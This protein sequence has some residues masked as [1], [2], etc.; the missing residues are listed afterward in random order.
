MRSRVSWQIG[1]FTHAPRETRS[2]KDQ[3]QMASDAPI[4]PQDNVQKYREFFESEGRPEVAVETTPAAP[5]Q[6]VTATL[7]QRESAQPV[8]DG[9]ELKE[10]TIEALR[11]ML[12]SL[13]HDND[14]LRDQIKTRWDL[15]RTAMVAMGTFFGLLFAANLYGQYAATSGLKE[16]SDLLQKEIDNA[17]SQTKESHEA[18]AELKKETETAVGN[19]KRETENAVGEL[20]KET[21]ISA[22]NHA[23]R[24]G[25]LKTLI[26]HSERRVTRQMSDVA[27]SAR[28]INVVLRNLDLGQESFA[29]NNPQR[30]LFYAKQ[31]D[32]AIESLKTTLEPRSELLKSLEQ[33]KPSIG[34]LRTQSAWAIGNSTEAQRLADELIAADGTFVEARHFAGLSRLERAAEESSNELARRNHL[35]QAIGHLEIAATTEDKHSPDL[36]FLAAACYDAGYY[37]DCDKFATRYIQEFPATEIERQR[38]SHDIQA[39]LMVGSIWKTLAGLVQDPENAKNGVLMSCRGPMPEAMAVVDARVLEKLL[40]RAL[41]RSAIYKFSPVQRTRYEGTCRN[42]LIYI[43][44][45]AGCGGG[46]PGV[47]PPYFP[48]PPTAAG[49]SRPAN[50]AP[51]GPAAPSE[52]GAANEPARRPAKKDGDVRTPAQVAPPP[53]PEV[54]QAAEEAAPKPKA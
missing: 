31:A 14:W 7:T 10:L 49:P 32:L 48:P 22:K 33:M 28:T 13:R 8:T 53:P 50:V 46:E 5:Q 40:T 12:D 3:I 41:A 9:A 51:S 29:R 23:T 18:V 19:L 39:Y 15:P 42:G 11:T 47:W 1:A 6:P 52:P 37:G 38:L 27:G 43:K 34:I 24:E 21:E 35:E 2:R 16:R 20:K 17:K 44:G 45:F 36:V 30:A 54:P 4:S 25:E 26:D